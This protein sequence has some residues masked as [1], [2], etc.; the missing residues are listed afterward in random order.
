M[1]LHQL[2]SKLTNVFQKYCSD[3]QAA[4]NEATPIVEQLFQSLGGCDLCFGRGYTINMELC[5]CSRAA[6]LAE[7]IKHKGAMPETHPPDR[8]FEEA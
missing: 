4:A 6:Q 3:P 2:A 1:I 5:S 7:F 8:K